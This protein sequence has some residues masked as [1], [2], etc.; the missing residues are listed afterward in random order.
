MPKTS[1]I[2]EGRR[3]RTV[4]HRNKWTGRKEQRASKRHTN[5]SMFLSEEPPSLTASIANSLHFLAFFF[6]SLPFSPSITSLI[7]HSISS[8]GTIPFSSTLT[9]TP[10]FQTSST[11][12]AFGGWSDMLP[13]ATYTTDLGGLLLIQL[14]EMEACN[15]FKIEFART[16]FWKALFIKTVRNYIKMDRAD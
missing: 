9:L 13:K 16:T 1:V 10:T 4:R 3:R 11:S 8:L 14:V 5:S 15:V 7:Q 12:F 6:I 2:E